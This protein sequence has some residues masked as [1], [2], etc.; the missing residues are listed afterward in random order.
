MLFSRY[1]T[2]TSS[3]IVGTLTVAALIFIGYQG[4]RP[5]ADQK[6]WFDHNYS[7]NYRDDHDNDNDDVDTA[8]S[9]LTT[10]NDFTEAYVNNTQRAELNIK[11]GATNYL[12]EDTTSQLFSASIRQNKGSYTLEKTSRDSIEIVTFKMREKK[13]EWKM[14]DLDGNEAVIKIN[15]NPLW[16]VNVEMGAGKTDFDLT[17]FK[18]NKL[19]LK[20]GAASFSA[21]LGIPVTTT[22]VSVETGLAAVEINVP[23]SVPCRI[24]VDSGLSSKDF[25]GFEKQSDGSFIAGKYQGAAKKIDI[26]LKGGI[27]QFQV[28]RY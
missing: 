10:T 11:G 23:S 16:D 22:N 24:I 17:P 19:Q 13:G 4:S 27:S 15:K 14:N 26:K 18:I 28:N 3:L 21:K 6:S 1:D 9:N 8:D 2:N 20:G 12:I 7:F 5:R 25:D